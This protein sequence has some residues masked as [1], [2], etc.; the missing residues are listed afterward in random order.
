MT[1]ELKPCPF[2]GRRVEHVSRACNGSA[3]GM[4]YIVSCFCG[5]YCACAHQQEDTLGEVVKAWNTRTPPQPA[6]QEPT[7]LT[8]EQVNALLKANGYGDASALE[9]VAF[10]CG[11]RHGELAHNIKEHT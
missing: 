9:R 7:A 1:E 10:I 2:C 3:T 5:S 4:T 11:L 6:Q 8:A